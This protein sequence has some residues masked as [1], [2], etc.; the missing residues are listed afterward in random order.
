MKKVNAMIADRISQSK[1]VVTVDNTH[2]GL[3]FL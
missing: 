3:N 2:Q 1:Y